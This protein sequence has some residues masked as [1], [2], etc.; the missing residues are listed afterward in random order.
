MPLKLA[1]AKFSDHFKYSEVGNKTLNVSIMV[2]QHAYKNVHSILFSLK[3][4]SEMY[5]R[6]LR[7]NLFTVKSNI[8]DLVLDNPIF[9]YIGVIYLNNTS[10]VVLF[11]LNLYNFLFSNGL[12]V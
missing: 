4:N 1:L 11:M 12:R 10:F 8:C 6:N 9:Y 5:Y 2:V 7:L 3:S